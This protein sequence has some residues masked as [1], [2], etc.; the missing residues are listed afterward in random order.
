MRRHRL[1]LAT[2]TLLIPVLLLSLRPALA[3][4]FGAS[5][6]YVHADDVMLVVTAW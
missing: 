2:L 1:K 6:I 4:E 3:E 5:P